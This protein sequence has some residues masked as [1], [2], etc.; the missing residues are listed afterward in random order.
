MNTQNKL[1]TA[2]ISAIYHT[3]ESEAE[4][5]HREKPVNEMLYTLTA[6]GN[7]PKEHWSDK[8]LMVQVDLLTTQC[9]QNIAMIDR[10]RIERDDL[11][12][13]LERVKAAKEESRRQCSKLIQANE[14]IMQ[15]RDELLSA[16]KDMSECVKDYGSQVLSAHIRD[17][18]ETHRNKKY[19]DSIREDI[20]SAKSHLAAIANCERGK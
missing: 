8:D 3:K 2:K 17:L 20:E 5:K 15:Q 6:S 1:N 18:G 4:L 16:L 12:A 11:Q 13:E 7:A 19:Q 9:G 10:L 14:K